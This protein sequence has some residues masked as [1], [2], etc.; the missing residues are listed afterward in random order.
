MKKFIIA[1]NNAHKAAEI[2]RIL[3]P[4][5]ITAVT[6]K[7]AGVNLP[8]VEETGKTFTENARL[9]AQS[10]FDICKAPVIA[11]DSGLVVDVLNGAPGVYSARY[12]GEGASD[13]DKINKLL[14]ELEGVPSDRR[15]AAFVCSICCILENS[16]IIEVSGRCE[17]KI[18]LEPKGEGGFGYDPVFITTDGKSYAELLEKEKDSISHRGNAL[19]AF[20]AE[21]AKVL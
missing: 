12:A 1:S 20:R 18:A 13:K 14:R 21:L 11:D 4:L 15:T 5:G 8:E 9:K 2:N 17:G 16:R 3:T 7:Q 19:R 6:A 10:A